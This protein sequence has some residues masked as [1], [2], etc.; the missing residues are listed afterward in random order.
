MKAAQAQE[1]AQIRCTVRR[2]SKGPILPTMCLR[3]SRMQEAL[4]AYKSK[5]N[6]LP[7]EHPFVPIKTTVPLK[8]S[9]CAK[10]RGCARQRRGAP[11][12]GQGQGPSFSLATRA[13]CKGLL[14]TANQAA[15]TV[16]ATIAPRWPLS[17]S[18]H[19]A[20]TLHACETAVFML[21]K[22]AEQPWQEKRMQPWQRK[23]A[24]P[25]QRKRA[26]PWQGK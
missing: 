14:L 12:V 2:T 3:T 17:L 19:C 1:G 21:H 18:S 11:V 22:S 26:Q 8:P 9:M 25:W 13:S 7:A 10:T 4:S 16:C 15:G 23:R 20:S 5:T 6:I 24:Q